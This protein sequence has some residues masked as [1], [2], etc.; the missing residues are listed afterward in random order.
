MIDKRLKKA[1]KTFI[2]L[3]KSRNPFCMKLTNEISKLADNQEKF[4]EVCIFVSE[5]PKK[6][7]TKKF[8]K[9][10]K[11][12]KDKKE[13]IKNLYEMNKPKIN[14]NKKILCPKC[15]NKG[16]RIERCHFWC[17]GCKNH[18]F[19]DFKKDVYIK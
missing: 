11:D 16:L 18:F 14:Y 9:I 3:D 19:Y 6:A 2:E 4:I 15:N 8:I 10:L 12:F 5:N 7:V 13:S 17:D 1:W